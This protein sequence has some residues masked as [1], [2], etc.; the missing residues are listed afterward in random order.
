MAIEPSSILALAERLLISERNECGARSAIS[1]AY[2]AAL[3]MAIEALP[4]ELKVTPKSRAGKG[5]HQAVIDSMNRWGNSPIIG[6]KDAVRAVCL[7]AQ[8]KA[9]RVKADYYL[10]N[11]EI[12]GKASLFLNRAKEFSA[13]MAPYRQKPQKIDQD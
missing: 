12:S 1:R 4:K 13:Y 9:A 10:R 11:E 7:L 6:R 5:S 3:H 2:Y 8:L